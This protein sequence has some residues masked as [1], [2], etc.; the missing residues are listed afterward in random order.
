MKLSVFSAGDIEYSY[1]VIEFEPSEEVLKKLSGRDASSLQR[2]L[3]E[4][5]GLTFTS[6]SFAR[7]AMNYKGELLDL[8]YLRFELE[9]GLGFEVEIYERSARSFSNTNPQE[10]FSIVNKLISAL[11][12]DIK[13]SGPRLISYV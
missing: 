3:E 6:F 8:A 1:G 13:L 4:K 2:E 9:D 12:P 5:T 11:Y 7:G 10:H